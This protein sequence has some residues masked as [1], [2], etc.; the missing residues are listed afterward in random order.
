MEVRGEDSRRYVGFGLVGAACIISRRGK[1][2]K[3]RESMLGERE[4]TIYG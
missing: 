4:G 3:K 1:R 2:K